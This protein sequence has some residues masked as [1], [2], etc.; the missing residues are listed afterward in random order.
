MQLNIGQVWLS[1]RVGMWSLFHA[2]DLLKLRHD[3][4]LA[5]VAEDSQGLPTPAAYCAM[6]Y[7]LYLDGLPE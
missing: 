4:H 5:C 1:I 2:K 7:T 3:L 6:W